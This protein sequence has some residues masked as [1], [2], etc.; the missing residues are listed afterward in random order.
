MK[1]ILSTVAI[2]A[3]IT[4]IGCDGMVPT[5]PNVTAEAINDGAALR[6][7]WTAVADADEYVIYI[8]GS[9]AARITETSYDVETPCKKIEVIASNSAGES[10]PATIDLTPVSTSGI[11]V[12]PSSDPSADHPSGI[13]FNVT[14][15]TVQALAIGDENNHPN[16]D[17]Y[18]DDKKFDVPTLVSPLDG[19]SV[20]ENTKG[21]AIA[22]ANEGDN[23]APA[24]DN[25]SSRMALSSGGMY[26]LWLDPANDGWSTDDHYVFA[27]VTGYDQATGK[28]TFE[29]YFQKQGGL[30]WVVTE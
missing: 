25:Y 12:W 13:S 30:R 10:D 6:L 11:E 24:P 15:G 29:F 20:V 26:W 22:E 9:E 8:D 1:K 28:F 19:N 23:M 4:L 3:I 17:Y 7:T 16:I 27:K 14:D 5:T 2:I 18:I 21:N